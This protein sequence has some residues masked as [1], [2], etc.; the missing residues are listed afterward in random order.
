MYCETTWLTGNTGCA[1]SCSVSKSTHKKATSL[2]K[3]LMDCLSC[4]SLHHKIKFISFPRLIVGLLFFYR[5]NQLH[6]KLLLRPENFSVVFVSFFWHATARKD[7]RICTQAKYVSEL[8][9]LL[10]YNQFSHHDGKLLAL[11]VE[12]LK[13]AISWNNSFMSKCVS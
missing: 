11:Y 2:G 9:L 3:V 1:L 6:S 10:E 13:P 5:D 7:K 8:T 12:S 4:T